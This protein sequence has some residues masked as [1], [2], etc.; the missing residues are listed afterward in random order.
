MRAYPP[1][2]RAR[3]LKAFTAS[4]DARAVAARFDVSRAWVHRVVQRERAGIVA[5]PRRRVLADQAAPLVRLVRAAP[6]VTLQ[7]LRAALRTTAAL[8][9]IA[10]ELRRLGCVRVV[11]VRF[12]PAAESGPQ[13]VD[14]A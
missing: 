2:L 1:S 3:V 11:G 7:E 14:P 13:K 4:G 9:T 12:P 10:R 5:R 6:L 8:S